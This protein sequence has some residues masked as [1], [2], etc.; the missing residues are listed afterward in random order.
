MQSHTNA[1]YRL[2]SWCRPGTDNHERA[3]RALLR[4]AMT[5]DLTCDGLE[6]TEAAN[7][8]GDPN[9][10]VAVQNSWKKHGLQ[11]SRMT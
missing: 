4:P 9:E 10:A 6:F 3:D 2:M 8:F 5:F 1:S 11:K 7:L